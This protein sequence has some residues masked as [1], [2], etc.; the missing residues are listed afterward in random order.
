VTAV[1]FLGLGAIG[2]PMAM[3]VASRF[4][5]VVWNR[6]GVRAA[7]FAAAT[8]ARAAGT[9]RE[10]VQGAPIVV[11]CLPTSAEVEALLDGPDGMLAGLD[12]GALLVDCTSGDPASSRRIAARLETLGFGFIDA[13]V[14]GG[15]NGAEAGTLTVMVGGDAQLFDRAAPVLSAFG[16]R[17]VRMGPVG[18]GHAMKAVNNALLAVNILAVGEGLAALVKA[19][20][21]ARTALNVLNASSGRSFVSETLV[22]D[23]VMTGAFPKTFKLTLLQKDAGIAAGVL[24]ETGV[25]GP[26]IDLAFRLYG[27]ARTVLGDDADYLEAIKAIEQQA[28]VEIRG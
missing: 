6:T 21:P 19:G 5:L 27:E 8:G 12:P 26:V 1:A 9:P 28:G 24:R 2:R 14:S 7:E 25:T 20:V 17:I 23:R 15:T 16:S 11:T 13:P 22:P 4:P 18:A 3:R 10:A